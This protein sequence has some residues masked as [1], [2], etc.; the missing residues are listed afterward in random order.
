[1]GEHTTTSPTSDGGERLRGAARW[2]AVAVVLAGLGLGVNHVVEAALERQLA[3]GL[4]TVR[5]ADVLAL[6][7]W[8]E[9]QKTLAATMAAAPEFVE[10]IAEQVRLA[11]ADADPTALCESRPLGGLRRSIGAVAESLGV[12]EFVITDPA[13]RN[14][15]ALY[16]EAVGRRTLAERSGIFQRVLAG[17]PAVSAPFVDEGQ[18][19]A[20]G[21]RKGLSM[22]AAAP[23]VHRGETIA[24]LSLRLDP[25]RFF[26]LLEVARLGETGDTYAFDAQGRLLSP[27]RNADELTRL[28]LLAD[29][30][31]APLTLELRDPGH[32]LRPGKPRPVLRKG[33]PLTRG[34]AAAIETRSPGEDVHGYRNLRGALVVGAWTWLEDCG[35]GV[36]T[37]QDAWEAYRPVNLLRAATWTLFGLLALGSLGG[38]GLWR[39]LARMRRRM[40]KVEGRVRRLGQYVLERKIGEG[41]M[42]EV[43]LAAHA[44]LRRPTAIK[45]LR[46][47][48]GVDDRALA[49]FEREVQITA[50]LTHPNTVAV[51]DYGRTA[52]GTF[53]YA[54][55][56][57][58]GIPLDAFVERQGPLPSE[59][60]IYIL[61]QVCA[62]LDEAHSLGLIHRDIKPANV[63]L[64][65]RGNAYDVVKVLDFGL[66]KQ[67]AAPADAIKLSDPDAIT[68]TPLSMSPEAIEAPE[69]V[70]P[71]SDLYAVGA[72]GYTLLTGCPVFEGK[73]PLQVFVQHVE[74][75]PVPPSERLGADGMPVDPELERLILRCLEKDPERRP[76]SAWALEVALRACPAA[77]RWD[78]CAARQW[79]EEHLPRLRQEHPELDQPCE[80]CEAQALAVDLA[81]RAPAVETSP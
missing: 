44:M 10:L 57:L 16:D 38:V 72:L 20:G 61:R 37:E 14:I 8:L 80:A 60:V 66:V 31:D 35:F 71:R 9:T 22:I 3:S 11:R 28:G 51:Y 59:R 24:V 53:Y 4:R 73:T 63:M 69:R 65:R 5:D 25:A 43:Y 12:V 56:Y 47:G 40:G 30:R 62:S 79:W 81:G 7:G 17:T 54:M 6:H 21:L 39:R 78:A 70:G 2:A 48:R 33:L 36:I 45:L 74:S 49:R 32:R 75:T 77:P 55:E 27:L 15:G 68:G 41:G 64:C 26:R 19:S 29:G 58:E 76:E 34:V 50:R 13:G 18:G 1:M 67:L 52:D 46:P 23:V 42:G